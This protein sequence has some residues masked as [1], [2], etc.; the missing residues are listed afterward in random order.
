MGKSFLWSLFS[1]ISVLEALSDLLDMSDGVSP[2]PPRKP[3][4][5]G[6]CCGTVHCFY[7]LRF[8]PQADFLGSQLWNFSLP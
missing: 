8:H 2:G 1:P 5:N 7:V 6:T 3:K 4:E